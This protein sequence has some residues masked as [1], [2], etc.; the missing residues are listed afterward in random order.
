MNAAES[1]IK[2]K[3]VVSHAWDGRQIEIVAEFLLVCRQEREGMEFITT[4]N[5]QQS[6][7][8][9]DEGRGYNGFKSNNKK[10]RK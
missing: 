8:M 6:I 2:H 1:Y 9:G 4:G 7:G 5:R 10:T 3:Q